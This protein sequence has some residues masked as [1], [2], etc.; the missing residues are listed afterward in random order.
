MVKE[1]KI[2]AIILVAAASILGAVYLVVINSW[3]QF[4]QITR[5]LYQACLGALEFFS[6]SG[7]VGYAGLVASLILM[8]GLSRG[9]WFILKQVYFYNKFKRNCNLAGN[10]AVVGGHQVFV[11]DDEGKFAF[12]AGW[13]K[14]QIYLS[15]GLVEMLDQKELQAVIAHEKYHCDNFHPLLSLLSGFIKK[16]L[17]FVPLVVRWVDF[18]A[19]RRE[20]KADEYTIRQVGA[21]SLSSSLLKVIKAQHKIDYGFEAQA[22]SS[23]APRIE[24]ILYKRQISFYIP[25][26][27]IAV[28]AAVILLMIVSI[29]QV[30]AQPNPQPRATINQI[31]SACHNQTDSYFDYFNQSPLHVNMSYLPE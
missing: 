23:I 4:Q 14:P 10:L 24:F 13:I 17:F 15:T 30:W 18:I 26:K 7:W 29:S 6:L 12:S 5:S 2:I 19:V 8:T 9:V 21:E 27:I 1:S 20:I 31:G 28:S 25:A 22:F 16:V 11:I 3:Y